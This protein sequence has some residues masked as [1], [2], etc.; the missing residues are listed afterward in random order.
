MKKSSRYVAAFLFLALFLLAPT[1][2]ATA[3]Q[4]Q[5][6]AGVFGGYVVPDDLDVHFPNPIFSF[7]FGD[8]DLDNSWM[9]GAKLGWIP[10]WT[11]RFLALEIEYNH[12]F[13]Q[14]YSPQ[15]VVGGLVREEGKIK[16]DNFLLDALVR[17][18]KGR[19]HPYIGVGIGVSL[20]NISGTE[21]TPLLG[22]G[23]SYDENDTAFAWQLL[24]G[25]DID[26]TKNISGELSY[27]YFSTEP[28][29]RHAE[30]DYISSLFTI[31][32]N[33]HF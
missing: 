5:F 20:F 21:S 24:G 14:D 11:R 33:F 27:R 23:G 6:Y 1:I 31:G 2:D 10:T 7:S 8:L 32:I 15:Y 16:L 9:L 13:D 12:L 28:R 17:Y 22:S 19:F 18:P 29:F 30:V 26:I 3:Q 4:K 25:I